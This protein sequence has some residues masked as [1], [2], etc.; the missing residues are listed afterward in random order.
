MV[1]SRRVIVLPWLIGREAIPGRMPEWAVREEG[2]GRFERDASGG[3]D[4][5]RLHGISHVDMPK[6]E[7]GD[8]GGGATQVA[9]SELSRRQVYPT[10]IER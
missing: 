7:L 2:L 8:Q 6:K 4:M 10:L 1:S 3:L 9:P 5:S